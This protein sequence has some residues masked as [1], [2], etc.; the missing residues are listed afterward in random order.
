MGNAN[1]TSLKVAKASKAGIFVAQIVLL[2]IFANG[3]S[4]L[5]SESL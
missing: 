2:P 4:A 1:V 5:S 3:N